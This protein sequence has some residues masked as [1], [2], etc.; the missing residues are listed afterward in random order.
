MKELATEIDKES[1]IVDAAKRLAAIKA[2]NKKDQKKQKKL[3]E[4]SEKKLKELEATLK[5]CTD[6][7]TR[8]IA[9]SN[10]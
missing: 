7:L 3:V 9:Q 10:T 6:Q 8:F 1:R 5:T 4:M 2:G